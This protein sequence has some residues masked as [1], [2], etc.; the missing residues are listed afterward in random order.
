MMQED[1]GLLLSF[2]NVDY[3]AYQERMHGYVYAAMQYGPV[4]LS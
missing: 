4:W 2:W 3:Y 1:S